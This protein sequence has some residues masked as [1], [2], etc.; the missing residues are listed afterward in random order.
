MGW[1]PCL[2]VVVVKLLTHDTTPVVGGEG[3]RWSLTTQWVWSPSSPCGFHGYCSGGGRLLLPSPEGM[4]VLALTPPGLGQGNLIR[5]CPGWSL[6]SPLGWDHRFSCGVWYQY[7]GY[8]MEV[9]AF[10]GCPSPGPLVERSGFCQGFLCLCLLL[11]PDCWLLW[12]SV[13]D[14]W[15][16]KETQGTHHVSFL[17]SQGTWL[18]CSPSTFQNLLIYFIF[19]VQGF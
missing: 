13:W 16:R 14:V 1:G 2:L 5:V 17:G 6:G 18:A 4:A 9:S 7:R 12:H 8:F 19:N 3:A 10:L 15:G 11:F